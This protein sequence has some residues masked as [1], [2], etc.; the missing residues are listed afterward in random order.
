MRHES[1]IVE[2]P[3]QDVEDAVAWDRRRFIKGV[4]IAVLTVQSLPLIGYAS[5]NPSVDGNDQNDDLIIHSGPG[6]I[7]HVHDLLIPYAVLKAPPLQ[8]VRLTTTQAFLHRHSVALTREQLTTVE[9]GGTV[10]KKASSH[11][12]TIALAK[13]GRTVP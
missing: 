6:L 2:V 12:F 11:L 10:V 4:G 13:G 1:G 9:Q 8:G 7:S 3:C 5:V